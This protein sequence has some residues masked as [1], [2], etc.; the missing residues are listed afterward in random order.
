MKKGATFLERF[1]GWFCEPIEKLRT[2]CPE[3]N[4]GYLAMS[5]A[6]YLCE[7]YYRTVTNTHEWEARK[8]GNSFLQAAAGDLNVDPEDFRI[9]WT[10]Y[11]HGIQ[12]QGMPRRMEEKGITYIWQMSNDFPAIPTFVQINPITKAIRIEPWKFAELIISKYRNNP[13]VLQKA[14]EH[15]FGEVILY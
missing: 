4:G 15:A 9:F 13:D 8:D 6:L 2:C 12:H 3:G 1:E 11:R 14:T 5:A 10:V 7:R